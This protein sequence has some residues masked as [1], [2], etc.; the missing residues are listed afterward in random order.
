M[1]ARLAGM[2]RLVASAPFII[3]LVSLGIASSMTTRSEARLG[4]VP[5]FDV[6]TLDGRRVRYEEIWQRRNLVLVI[7]PP[8]EREAAARYALELQAHRDELEQAETTVVVT[9]DA[10]PVQ[11][12]AEQGVVPSGWFARM[13]INRRVAGARNARRQRTSRLE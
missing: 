7:V 13:S 9:A 3:E 11:Q 5:H 2:G 10:V 12:G 1:P 8:H 4:H 6:T